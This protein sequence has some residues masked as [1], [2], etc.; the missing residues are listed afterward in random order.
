MI[1]RAALDRAG[2]A[3]AS[4]GLSDSPLGVVLKGV[5][6]GFAGTLV[7]GLALKGAQWVAGHGGGGE[8]QQSGGQAEQA[9]I[10]AG[11]ALAGGQVQAPFLDRSTELFAQKV[12]TGLFG[13]SLPGG[14]RQ[15]AGVATHFLYG[16]FWGAVYGVIQSSLG[17][18][19]A[20]HGPLYGLI[21]WLIGPVTLVP[22]MGIMPP[23]QRQGTRR[24]LLV[25]GFHVAYG[26]GLGLTFE[27]FT[28]R[29]RRR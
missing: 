26:L 4:D 23:P 12:A 2:H 6:A 10:G 11:Q 15:A 28:G 16:G 19:A 3:N 8:G 13:A 5:L 9:G 7:L 24:A 14:A 29:E 20:L 22:A 25:A 18:P 27:A 1:G 17:L 21:V